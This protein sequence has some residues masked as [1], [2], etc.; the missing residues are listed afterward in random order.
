MRKAYLVVILIIITL[1]AF[2]ACTPAPE[3]P[4]DNTL[5]PPVL[6]SPHNGTN[7]IQLSPILLWEAVPEAEVYE[8]QISRNSDFS[9]IAVNVFPVNT[10][11]ELS[12]DLAPST[13]YYW[14]VCAKVNLTDP[15]APV[16]C[17]E[18]WTFTTGEQSEPGPQPEPVPEPVKPPSLPET[19]PSTEPIKITAAQLATEYDDVGLAAETKYRN[20]LL[21]VSGTFDYYE[22]AVN[23]PFI[24]FET[25]PDAWEIRAFPAD[26][27]EINKAKELVKG[28]EIVITGYCKGSTAWAII[29]SDC[30][31]IVP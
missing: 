18:I 23:L 15:D 27:N 20:K 29:L 26:A 9:D 17:S 19:E 30:R 8:L 22:I 2:G 1:F 4:P 6:L 21:E 5:A 3:P 28:D 31:F 25:D 12:V 14:M 10:S 24:T 13:K 11:Y 7:G 16:A